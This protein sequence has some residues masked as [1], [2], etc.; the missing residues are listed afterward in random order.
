MCRCRGR[1]Q[2]CV[3]LSAPCSAPLP[4]LL[5]AVSHTCEAS[6]FQCLNGHC[7]P[8][9]WACDGDADCQD[10]SDE[11]PAD[12]GMAR[13]HFCKPR[14]MTPIPPNEGRRREKGNRGCAAVFLYRKGNQRNP[15]NSDFFFVRKKVQ[16]LP[17]PQWDLH[18]DQQAL[19]W[20]HRLLRCLR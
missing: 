5:P 9:R 12:C 16:R 15:P 6:S 13:G 1:A 17:V 8:Q 2:G 14:E 18:P 10:G 7:I 11:D 20:H 19:R 4:A 3:V